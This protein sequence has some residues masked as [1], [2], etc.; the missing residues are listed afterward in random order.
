M[1]EAGVGSEWSADQSAMR[2]WGRV[3]ASADLLEVGR[4][5]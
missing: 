2:P 4:A 5:A 3:G 1:T